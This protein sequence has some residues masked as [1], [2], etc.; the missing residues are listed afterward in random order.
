[1]AASSWPSLIMWW[2]PKIGVPFFAF[3]SLLEHSTCLGEHVL[4]GYA[5]HLPCQEGRGIQP[6]TVCSLIPGPSSFLLGHLR[7]TITSCELIGTR[8]GLKP[9]LLR[10]GTYGKAPAL[11]PPCSRRSRTQP[12]S[13]GT[14]TPR[15]SRG[16]ACAQGL[17]SGSRGCRQGR[18]VRYSI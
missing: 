14:P 12:R 9:F 13:L 11:S 8:P 18:G 2:S 6:F 10:C 3:T 16:A 1:M 4:R 5:A 17:S 7:S 15:S